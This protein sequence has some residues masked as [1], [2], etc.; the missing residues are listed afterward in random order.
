MKFDAIIIGGGLSGLAC[1]ITLAE[2]GK[3]CAIVSSGQGALHFSSGSIDLLGYS[4]G[5]EVQN[6]LD[7]IATLPAEHPYSLVGAENV[8]AIAEAAPAFFEK[9]SVKLKGNSAKNHYRLTPV[10]NVRPTWLT[11][12]EYITVDDTL[13]GKKVLLLNV[14]G[15][16]DLPVK[17][18]TTG[19]EKQGITCDF[20]EFS[21]DE[22]DARRENASEMRSVN[23]AKVIDSVGVSKVANAINKKADGYDLV[24]LPAVFGW[25]SNDAISML[26]KLVKTEVKLLPTLPPSVSG[27]RLQTL[28]RKRF[29]ELGGVVLLGDSVESGKLENGKLQWVNTHNLEDEKLIADNYVLA[30]GNFFGHGLAGAPDEIYE[31][32]FGLDVVANQGRANWYNDRFFESQPYMSFGVATNGSFKAHKDGKEISNLYVAGS[33][34]SGANQVK[35]A[36]M[37]G[38]SLITGVY[39]AKLINKK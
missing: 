39:V 2:A 3:R 13:K 4:N 12:D 30:T 37:G 16:L 19:L 31:P 27:V 36:S 22:L 1:G 9:A 6:A 38:V 33:V 35:E 18:I 8:K 29:Q 21:F 34:L 5:E 14:A 11:I 20:A 10:G 32:I 28:L 24:L 26:K 25:N 17:F 7:A 23:I 15:Y